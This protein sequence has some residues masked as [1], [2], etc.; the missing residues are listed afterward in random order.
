MYILSVST[1]KKL[2]DSFTND[3]VDIAIPNLTL[4]VF[5]LVFKFR[6]NSH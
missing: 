4:M 3:D 1:H 6:M 2:F 5:K